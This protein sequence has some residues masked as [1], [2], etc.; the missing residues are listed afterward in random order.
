[1]AFPLLRPAVAGIAVGMR[2]ADEARANLKSFAA[3]VPAQLWT[4][5]RAADLIRPA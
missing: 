3:D 4:D 2:S 5:L 1:M